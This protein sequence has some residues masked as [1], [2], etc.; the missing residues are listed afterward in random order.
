VL[1][2]GW[3]VVVFAFH[4]GAPWQN[5][6]FSLAYLP[7]LAILVASGLTWTWRRVDR[8]V[9]VL[10]GVWTLLG[11]VSM[12]VGG[13]RLVQGF[14]DRKAED[15]A[16]VHWVET[17][18]PP[19]ARLFSFGPTLTFRHYASYPTFDLYDITPT[20]LASVLATPAPTYVLL[21]EANVERQWLGAAPYANFRWLREV[22]GLVRVGDQGSFTLFR[23]LSG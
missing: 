20:D 12:A 1:I 19:S 4:A 18:T 6:R 15:L 2:V 8:R 9:G 21:D 11:L 17:Q 5:F 22:A 13:T 23:V 3:A 7:P 10:V 16:L 14:V